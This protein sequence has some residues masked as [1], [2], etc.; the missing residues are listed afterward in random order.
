MVKWWF[1]QD[2]CL[3]RKSAWN[4]MAVQHLK[5]MLKKNL[6]TVWKKSNSI[7]TFFILQIAARCWLF[8]LYWSRYRLTQSRTVC[9]FRHKFILFEPRPGGPEQVVS[10]RCRCTHFLI[11]VLCTTRINVSFYELCGLCGQAKIH[12]WNM[13]YNCTLIHQGLTH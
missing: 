11:S 6:I 10:T 13:P 3:K 5:Q 12:F 2:E 4:P 1:C 8:T 9:I 7:F